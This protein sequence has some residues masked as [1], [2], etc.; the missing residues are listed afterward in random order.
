MKLGSLK[1]I[2]VFA[3]NSFS[4]SH[5]VD[6]LLEKTPARVIGI[7]RSRELSPIFLPYLYQQKRPRRFSFYQLD[8]NK[9]SRRIERILDKERPELIINFLAQ[10]NSQYS[11]N[12]PLDWFETNCLGMVKLLD[13]LRKKDYLKKYIQISTPEIYGDCR[14][15]K[16]NLYYFNPSNPYAASKACA[17][18]F[19]LALWKRFRFP[20]CFTRS[21]NVYG[22]HQQ[23]YRL[24]P[25]SII[26]LKKGQLIPLHGGGRFRRSF[27]HINDVIKGVGRVIEKG[28]PGQLYHFS[29]KPTTIKKIVQLICQ[30]MGRPFAQSV[31]ISQARAVQD[32]GYELD[33]S[34][35]RNKLGWQPQTTLAEGIEET[36]KWVE[37]NWAELSTRPLEYIHQK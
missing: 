5:G 26:L 29:N 24:I 32:R 25:R 12:E 17:D 37:N 20:V 10:G 19:L 23:L 35:A 14:N 9:D 2:A 16:E 36:I 15:F 11:W 34:K 31:A 18:L 3:S 21:A 1:K 27:V 7:S 28:E 8:I 33:I 22:S 6:F 13:I 30:K 4:G